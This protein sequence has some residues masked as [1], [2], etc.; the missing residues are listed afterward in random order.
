[1]RRIA[2]IVMVLVAL[3]WVAQTNAHDSET[4]G[5]VQSTGNIAPERPDPHDWGRKLRT[6]TTSTAGWLGRMMGTYDGHESR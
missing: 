5:A 4:R 2:R 3:T 1:M 6:R